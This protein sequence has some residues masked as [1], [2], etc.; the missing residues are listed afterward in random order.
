MSASNRLP[1]SLPNYK[2]K[3]EKVKRTGQDWIVDTPLTAMINRDAETRGYYDWMDN[4]E[5]N[6]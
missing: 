1:Q 2:I 6:F 5:I 4:L 3:A